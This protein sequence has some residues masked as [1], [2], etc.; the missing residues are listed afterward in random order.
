FS[1]PAVAVATLDLIWSSDV[2][3]L[4]AACAV[5][6]ADAAGRA[7]N[8][9]SSA[10][11]RFMGPPVTR[12]TGA[13]GCLRTLAE[14]PRRQRYLRRGYYDAAP[15]LSSQRPPLTCPTSAFFIHR[16][17]TSSSSAPGSASSFAGSRSPAS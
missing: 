7:A 5:C 10:L 6:A 16:S 2:F 13:T 17:S 4:G 12:L 14:I 15:G 3:E 1:A 9:A 8:R 11:T